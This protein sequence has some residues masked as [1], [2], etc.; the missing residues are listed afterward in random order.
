MQTLEKEIEKV[1]VD[2]DARA[3]ILQVVYHFVPKGSESSVENQ[4]IWTLAMDEK[5]EKV[6]EATQFVDAAAVDDVVTMMRANDQ[7]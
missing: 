3:V 7:A 4:V 2:V 1:W 6:A 5:G